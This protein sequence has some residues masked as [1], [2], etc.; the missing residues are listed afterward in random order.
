MRHGVAG[1]P[2][3]A[4]A[5]HE[6]LS[7]IG[8]IASPY[9]FGYG[10]EYSPRCAIACSGITIRGA[11]LIAPSYDT[12]YTKDSQ[13]GRKFAVDCGFCRDDPSAQLLDS[14]HVRSV[15]ATAAAA[16]G[17][18][19]DAVSGSV[20]GT[21]PGTVSGSAAGA[22]WRGLCSAG[23]PSVG[24]VLGGGYGGDYWR[25]GHRDL[26]DDGFDG[27]DAGD[28]CEWRQHGLRRRFDCGD[29]YRGRDYGRGY[30]CARQATGEVWQ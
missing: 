8:R 27:E 12:F 22:V 26:P 28:G 17:P 24:V 16:A 23:N 7:W 13:C 20:C 29:R 30:G 4:G 3:V 1:R 10:P 18:S 21:V 11:A 14:R 6:I 25:G 2:F 5:F 15:Y 19:P 9:G